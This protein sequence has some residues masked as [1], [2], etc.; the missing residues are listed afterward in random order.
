MDK[1][2]LDNDYQIKRVS[3]VDAVVLQMV[4]AI[5]DG[6]FCIG[7]RIPS[8]K[9]LMQ[10]FDVSRST[11]REAFKKLESLGVVSIRQGH[12]TVLLQDDMS[13]MDFGSV[14]GNISNGEATRVAVQDMFTLKNCKL[15][16]YLEARESV[17]V[18]A[19]VAACERALP[20]DLLKVEQALDSYRKL[21]RECKVEQFLESDF[22]FH[23]SI[24]DASQNELYKQ[25][26]KTLTPYF[27]VQIARVSKTPGMIEN[28][29]RIHEEIYWALVAQD[30]EAGKVLIEDHL[31]TISGRMLIKAQDKLRDASCGSNQ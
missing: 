15:S 3:L 21:D 1:Y 4:R 27:Q 10:E 12:G 24:I 19:F 8:E 18:A 26:W 13:T 28:A 25:F 2:I 31:G 6:V 9:E 30:V 14:L 29:C 5:S 11:L 23:E 7:E 17:E 20:G 16:H 22:A